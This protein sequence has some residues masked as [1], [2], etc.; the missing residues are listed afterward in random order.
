MVVKEGLQRQITFLGVDSTTDKQT[1]A[2][3]TPMN[4]FWRCEPPFTPCFS[5]Y[6]MFLKAPSTPTFV[7]IS[8][9]RG[10]P[11]MSG[12]SWQSHAIRVHTHPF[13]YSPPLSTPRHG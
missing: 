1:T 7:E 2:L 5:L 6:N 11:V 9:L 13:L 12:E 3:S 8:R 10:P 4:V